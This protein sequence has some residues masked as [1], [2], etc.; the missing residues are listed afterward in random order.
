MLPWERADASQ[1]VPLTLSSAS[2]FLLFCSSSVLELLCQKPGL[3]QR[4][5]YPGTSVL[6]DVFW[7]LLDHSQEGL[8][9][10]HGSFHDPLPA[11]RFLAYHQMYRW[12]RLLLGPLV[13]SAGSYCSHKGTFVHGWL[14]NFC[15]QQRTQTRYIL[16]SHIAEVTLQVYIF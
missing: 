11:P 4:L 6:N 16:L 7:G 10:V 3:P 14:P 1:T 12:A 2:K 8:E 15:C 5:Y 13:Y 9:S